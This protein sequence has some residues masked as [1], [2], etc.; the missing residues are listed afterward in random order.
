MVSSIAIPS[1][2]G[3]I[4]IV[5]DSRLI[6]NNTNTIAI[7]NKGKILGYK[8]NKL[9][10]GLFIQNTKNKKVNKNAAPKEFI[11]DV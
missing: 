10:L 2:I 5:D 8:A 6:P 3:A 7:I 9:N 1:I 4:I 11:C